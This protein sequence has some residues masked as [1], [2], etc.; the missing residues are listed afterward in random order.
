MCA[1]CRELGACGCGSCVGRVGV[2]PNQVWGVGGRGRLRELGY[3]IA[4][5]ICGW[6]RS[7]ST[8]VNTF[9]HRRARVRVRWCVC[10]GVCAWL[11]VGGG[12]C[13]ACRTASERLVSQRESSSG[14]APANRGGEN[15]AA[16][17]GQPNL[18]GL[19]GAGMACGVWRVACASL[20]AGSEVVRDEF[21]GGLENTDQVVFLISAWRECR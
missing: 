1:V 7:Q 3:S 9:P 6:A 19:A 20:A 12:S 10:G 18:R 11:C 8:V 5:S 2:G 17:S 15:R 14:H 4:I 13:W 16:G 21:I